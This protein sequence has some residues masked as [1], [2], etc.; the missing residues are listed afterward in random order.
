[1]P[2]HLKVLL[3]QANFP[4]EEDLATKKRIMEAERKFKFW[5]WRKFLTSNNLYTMQYRFDSMQL[6][7]T[8]IAAGLLYL[9]F[10]WQPYTIIKSMTFIYA[11]ANGLNN[12]A[13]RHF[14]TRLIEKI[15]LTLPSEAVPDV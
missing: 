1:M 3:Y 5:S 13:E 8:G 6:Y 14:R 2:D 4:T 11:A 9:A 10:F 15:Y 7:S 12:F